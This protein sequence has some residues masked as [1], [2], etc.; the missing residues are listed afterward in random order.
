MP[1]KRTQKKKLKLDERFITEIKGKQFVLYAGL[2]DLAHQRGLTKLNVESAQYPTKE[3]GYVSICKAVAES[4]TGE[5]F[6]DIGDANPQ[7]VHSMVCK[8]IIRVASTRAKARCLRDFVN[9]G[10]TCLEE[11]G[12][13]DEVLGDEVPEETENNGFKA[14]GKSNGNKKPGKTEEK[15]KKSGNGNGNNSPKMSTAQRRAIENLAKRKKISAKELEAMAVRLYNNSLKSLSSN[16]AG[17]FIK[18]LSAA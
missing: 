14:N 9:V 17:Y 11:I 7:N 6:S 3:N 5:V 15:A 12:N 10:I 4:K 16:D 13:F 1:K 8:H 18:E 2:L